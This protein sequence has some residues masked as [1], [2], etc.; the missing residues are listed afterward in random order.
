MTTSNSRKPN[1][2][3]LEENQRIQGENERL[4]KELEEARRKSIQQPTHMT[5]Q[6]ST[7]RDEVRWALF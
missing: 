3:L 2:Q 4:R 7:T 1:Q 6:G 5:V